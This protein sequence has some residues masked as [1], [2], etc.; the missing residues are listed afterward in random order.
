ME[1]QAKSL[2]ILASENR[3][4]RRQEPRA[5]EPAEQP[6]ALIRF[7]GFQDARAREIREKV[8]NIQ[9]SDSAPLDCAHALGNFPEQTEVAN[10]FGDIR[11]DMMPS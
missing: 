1:R 10:L 7:F 8:T 4:R 6:A 3:I 2:Q 11:D 5:P 9:S